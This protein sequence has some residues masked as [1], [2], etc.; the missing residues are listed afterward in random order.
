MASSHLKLLTSKTPSTPT[1]HSRRRGRLRRGAPRYSPTLPDDHSNAR[2]TGLPI[3]R[4]LIVWGV[5]LAG[6]GALGYRLYQL[7][8]VEASKL[9]RLAKGQ[10]STSLQPYVP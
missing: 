10:Q 2:P 9:Q 8:V 1:A 5:L 3:V 4:L 7:Q 6:L